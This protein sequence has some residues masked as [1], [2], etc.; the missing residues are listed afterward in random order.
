MQHRWVNA[1]PLRQH[2]FYQRAYPDSDQGGYNPG[3]GRIN[4]IAFHPTNA[5]IIYVGASGGGL[6]KT[7]DGGASWSSLTDGMPDLAVFNDSKT[8]SQFAPKLD[9]MPIPVMTTL[10][11]RMRSYQ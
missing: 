8:S 11:I 10:F 5:N 6:W 4:E 3:N 9:T 7:I 1:V 2:R